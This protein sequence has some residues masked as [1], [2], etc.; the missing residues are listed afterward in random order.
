MVNCEFG[1]DQSEG[2]G[3]DG[4]DELINRHMATVTVIF[5]ERV[6]VTLWEMLWEMLRDAWTMWCDAWTMQCA[7]CFCLFVCTTLYFCALFTPYFRLMFESYSFNFTSIVHILYFILLDF[8]N[9]L[10]IPI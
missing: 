1:D 2:E 3:D 5:T 6:W 4:A 8:L 7:S 10:A 9:P